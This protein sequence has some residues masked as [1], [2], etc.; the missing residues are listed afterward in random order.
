VKLAIGLIVSHGFPAPNDFWFSYE[1]MKEHVRT[2]QTNALVPEH[3]KV[4]DLRVFQTTAF[5]V[6]VARNEVVRNVLKEG[7]DYLFFADCDQV[8]AADTIGRLLAH[9]KA[10]IS[11]RYHM[12]KEPY[13]AVAYVKHRMQTGAHAYAP[14]HWGQGVFEIERG[15]AGSLL[16]RRDV[17]EAIE[18]RIGP[19]WFRYQRGPEFP[20]DFTVSEDFWFWQQAREA[21]FQ[22]WLDW[23]V[24]AGHIQAM[25]I[26]RSWNE[27]YLD[28]QVRGLPDMTPEEREKALNSFVV[29]GLPDGLRLASGDHVPPYSYS[30]GER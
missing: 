28:A 5:P 21:G 6:D 15:G 24:E 2:G 29:C 3:L 9:D 30:P 8:F 16:I 7:Y 27:A 26:N 18:T 10:L 13:H 25:T 17:L 19:N 1:R 4:D 12:R 20:H 22:G 23:D 14:V 11:G